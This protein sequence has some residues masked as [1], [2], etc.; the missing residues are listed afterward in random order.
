MHVIKMHYHV[1]GLFFPHIPTNTMTGTIKASYKSRMAQ[2]AGTPSKA[3]ATQTTPQLIVIA[4][5][6]YFKI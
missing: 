4:Q 3:S 1:V 6:L 2:V 5:E